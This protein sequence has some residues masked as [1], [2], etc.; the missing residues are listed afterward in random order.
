[1]LSRLLHAAGYQHVRLKAHVL[2]LSADTDT[3]ADSYRNYQVAYY[4]LQPF[5][6]KTG[7]TSQQ[8]VERLYQQMLV[9]MQHPDFS[10][11]WHFMTARGTKP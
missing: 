6:V 5:L 1:M 11:I 3:W 2:E 8:E 9:E 10:G 4:L 7:V